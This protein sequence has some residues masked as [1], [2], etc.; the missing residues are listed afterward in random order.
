MEYRVGARLHLPFTEVTKEIGDKVTDKEL[1]DAKQNE[2]SIASLVQGKTLL[3]E[4]EYAEHLK[5]QVDESRRIEIQALEARLAELK[6][7]D[8]S[9][10]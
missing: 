10:G 7:G 6:K 4:E 5:S 1:A 2:E 8:G 3:S 9:E